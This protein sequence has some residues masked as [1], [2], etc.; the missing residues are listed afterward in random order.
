[1]T[2][3]SPAGARCPRC[4][5]AAGARLANGLCARCL[6]GSALDDADVTESFY[7]AHREIGRYRLLGEIAHGGVGVVYR[8]WQDDLRR[9]VALKM[10]LPSR[11][12]TR[13][14][15]DRFRR[16]A[17]AMASLDHAGI[18]P[19]YEVGVADGLPYFAMKLAERGNL[20][21]RIAS[22]KGDA[23][24]SA[25][26]ASLI[27]R[28]IAH[29][30]AR[31]VLH[32]D[33]KPSNIV[34]DADDRPL[35][36][37][38]GLARFL[39]QDSSLTGVDAVI[40]TPR[41][42]APEVVESAGARL[43]VAA[44]V[45]G[46]GAILYEMLTGR[47]PFAE[48]TS[49]E[50][51]QQVGTRR[52]L[53]PRAIDAT[54]PPALEAICL[55]CLEKRPGDRYASAGALADVL[56][57]WLA[58]AKAPLSARLRWLGLDVPS[59]RRRAMRVFAA[60]AAAAIAFGAYAYATREPIPIPDPAVAARKVA[61]I[62]DPLKNPAAGAAPARRIAERLALPPPLEVLPFDATW[63]IALEHTAGTDTDLDIAVGAM[64]V[65]VVAPQAD[66][67]FDLV[68]ADDFRQERL[69][70]TTYTAGDEDRVV[71]EV[72]AAIARK[73]TQ[74]T[75]EAHLSRSA[76]ASLMRAIRWLT[77]PGEGTNAQAIAALK[78]VLQQS[79][80]SAL[81][82]A[83]LSFAYCN[84]RG[85]AFWLDT[86]IDEAAR[87]E[88]MDPTLGF[89]TAQ[90]GLAYQ[91]KGWSARAA[92]AFEAAQALGTLFTEEPLSWIYFQRSRYRDAYRQSV[93]RLRFGT[94]VVFPQIMAAEVLFTVGET[95]AGERALRK[96]M[97]AETRPASRALHEAE[98]AWYRGD[99][100]RCRELAAKLEPEDGDGFFTASSLIR[101]C[102]IEQGDF[103]A[104]LAT[105]ADTER[106]YANDVGAPNGNHPALRRAILLA[107]LERRGEVDALLKQARPGLQAAIDASTDYPPVWLRMAA[108]ERLA[109]EI[110]AAY[111]TLEHAFALGLTVNPHN[112]ADVEFLPFR[113]E[114]RFEALRARS[115]A[116]IAEE[117]QAV[118][119]ALAAGEAAVVYAA[120]KPEP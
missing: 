112:R 90:L 23:H 52:V 73:R 88:R 75:A 81:A 98:I 39:A 84:H 6:I 12:E 11:L 107:S 47:A 43:T 105:M 97:A 96:A 4:G 36:T 89:A 29:A 63:A 31:G 113:G 65:V 45:Y 70:E 116:L 56:D 103:V 119:Q 30:H 114:P 101:S 8:A 16:E 62:A 48:L 72:S 93:E 99:P 40:G 94:D 22:R 79:P 46:L 9:T 111:A 53:A 83:W 55:R 57:A 117:R 74:P 17:E 87:A 28:A 77:Y 21:E 104:A 13:D 60:V 18:L 54:I 34:F 19:V 26:L 106:A 7:D 35:V 100:A 49:L 10:L 68:V 3:G 15:R 50:I 38:F 76:L 41:Y 120:S 67:A 42:V 2:A 92:T 5:A 69:Y 61:V 24:E 95:D 86:A 58:G 85:E 32:R 27:A 37:D 102:A 20:A 91:A 14:A 82:H 118:Q 51:L 64:T 78:D 1:M 110:D 25:R 33:L 66:G 59:R 80:D 115:D 108:A 109:G 71:R 44:D